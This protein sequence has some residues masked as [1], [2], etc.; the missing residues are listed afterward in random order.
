MTD[1]GIPMATIE[2]R[3]VTKTYDRPS[4]PASMGRGGRGTSGSQADR[5]FAE[6]VTIQ[7]RSEYEA[8]LGQSGKITAL[9]HV[10]ATF[11]DGQT[12]AV[13]GPSGCGKSTLLRVV[14]G[15]D[16]QYSG[17]VLYDGQDVVDVPA[18][19][20]YI[21]MV[22]QNYALYPHFRSKGNLGFFFQ[23]RHLPDAEAEER[24]RVTADM[25]GIDF[26]LLLD[27][28]PGTL[29]GGQQQR[30][31]I[32]RAL[33]RQP[34]LFLFDEPLSNL[35][36]KLRTQ[37]RVE[38]KR[39][40]TRFRIT[41]IYVTH[42]QV[43][44]MALGDLIAVMRAGKI[45]QM[46]DYQSLREDPK[47]SFVA[48]FLGRPPM[49]LLPGV[50]AEGALQLAGA[51]LALP[52]SIRPKVQAGQAVTLGARPESM[53]WSE[54]DRAKPGAARVRGM[55]ESVEPD[56]AYHTQTLYIRSGELFFAATAS[57]DESVSVGDTVDVALPEDGLYFFDSQTDQRIV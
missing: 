5:A 11:P 52:E 50:V 6:R 18:K 40:L 21:G 17:Q 34:K 32:A 46:G 48:G 10:S 30:V 47:T 41:A 36:A 42:D 16:T 1:I 45:E 22:F 29:S 44:A 25:M 28:K 20:R 4:F 19:D 15:L 35:D 24:I 9:D 13:V 31:A 39:L 37:T 3:D 12:V 7:S 33:V 23:V 49:N 8:K 27:R 26:K 51:G 57:Q 38:I 54:R 2:L 55:V 56:M 43:E 53:R 14:A